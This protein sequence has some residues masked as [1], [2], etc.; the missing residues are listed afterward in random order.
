[1]VA[2]LRAPCPVLKR[3][4]SSVIPACSGTE[5]MQDRRDT[6]KMKTTVMGSYPKIPAGPGPSVRSA[7]QRFEKGLLTPSQ[8]FETYS[9]VIDRV[10]ELANDTQLDRTTDGQIRW[11]DLFDPIVRD[12]D[13]VHS[14]GLIRLFDNNFYVRHPVITGRLQYQGGTLAAWC[15]E[16]VS[17]SQ[18]PIKVALPGLF[19]FLDLQ[20]D[21]SYGDTDTLIADLIDVMR[22]TVRHLVGTGVVEVQWDEP[23]LVRSSSWSR[24]QVRQAYEA[25]IDPDLE[26]EQSIALYWGESSPWLDTLSQLPFSRIS[27]DAVSDPHVLDVL[28]TDKLDIAVGLGVID[29]R[30]VRMET[31]EHLA[32]LLQPILRRQGH[33]RTWIHP[34]CGLEFLP[35]DRA[36]QK[37][38]LLRDTKF[39]INA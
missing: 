20:E 14:A 12:L 28:A 24:T 26:I 39:L 16:A 37:V 9:Q 13:N 35:P 36:E 31:P 4:Q 15:R 5:I 21:T 6:G 3:R 34:S 32:R 23:S 22:L 19:T 29:A 11:Y 18:V 17:R 27:C 30:N 10:L 2:G 38:R 33:E 8:L 25:L 1:M 7:I